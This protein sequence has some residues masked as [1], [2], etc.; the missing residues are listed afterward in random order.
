MRLKE[1]FFLQFAIDRRAYQARSHVSTLHKI[2]I[3]VTILA[4]RT[5]ADSKPTLYNTYI[6]IY[7]DLIFFACVM[8]HFVSSTCL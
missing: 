2:K 6:L 4:Y 3:E 5:L 8:C 1:Q 7:S